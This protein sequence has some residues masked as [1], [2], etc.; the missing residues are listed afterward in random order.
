MGAS[1]FWNSKGLSRPV[2]ELLYLT[3]TLH[4]DQYTFLIASSSFLLGMRNVCDNL[5]RK[6]QNTHFM[7]NNFSSKIV[8]FMR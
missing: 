2:M 1:T 4:E 6:Y 7:F 3:G 8:P 5:G